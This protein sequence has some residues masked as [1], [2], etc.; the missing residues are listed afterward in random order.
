MF[1]FHTVSPVLL[2]L[3]GVATPQDGG[4]TSEQYNL[5]IE[6]FNNCSC[7]HYY[8]C[9]NNTINRNGANLINVRAG[10]DAG[11][12]KPIVCQGGSFEGEFVCCG[13]QDT[14]M[15]RKSAD[16]ASSDQLRA[17]EDVATENRMETKLACGEQR[18][19]INPRILINDSDE[20]DGNAVKGE[21]PWLAAIYRRKG[22][23]R[24][25][26]HSSGTLI[27]P[28]VIITSNHYYNDGTSPD[29]YMVVMNGEVALSRSVGDAA[30]QRK[31]VEIINHP[32]YDR[33]ALYYDVALLILDRPFSSNSTNSINSICLPPDD[34]DETT[35]RCLV[36]GWGRGSEVAGVPVLKRVEVPL[37]GFDRC[38]DQLRKTRLG[39]YFEL[40][41]SFVCAGGE[42]NRDACMGDGGSPLMC[43]V[44]GTS[45]FYQAGIVA[46]GIG[47]GAENVPGV[48][49]S[50]RFVK[51]WIDEKLAGRNL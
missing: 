38:Q 36:A 30:H 27:N 19:N 15:T 33:D 4:T 23:G 11:E 12:N 2:L 48:Y 8:Q 40:H 20:I 3:F 6:V 16:G 17:P 9:N 44:P 25:K 28:R 51:G 1:N 47:C 31:V 34:A 49:A 5:I 45:R 18:T 50:T 32:N 46:W 24:W 10:G 39:G 41:K 14:S 43:Y 26:F 13:A 7:V 29:K 37:V 21:F 22:R 35:G 42:K